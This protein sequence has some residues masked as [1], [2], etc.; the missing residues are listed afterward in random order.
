[1]DRPY[2]NPGCRGGGSKNSR[3]PTKD[4]RNR[5]RLARLRERAASPRVSGTNSCWELR[6]ISNPNCGWAARPERRARELLQRLLRRRSA[7]QAQV[8]SKLRSEQYVRMAGAGNP[9]ATRPPMVLEPPGQPR[10]DGQDTEGEASETDQKGQSQR[11][12]RARLRL[13]NDRGHGA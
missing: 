13:H 5:H 3:S 4:N 11:D 7:A 8:P 10:E 12:W 1:V 9:L 2:A 6:Q